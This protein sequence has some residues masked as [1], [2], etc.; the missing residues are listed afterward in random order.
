MFSQDT[1]GEGARAEWCGVPDRRIFFATDVDFSMGNFVRSMLYGD[2]EC[3]EVRL[4][5]IV[6]HH[7]VDEEQ[8]REGSPGAIS[9]P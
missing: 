8:E 9:T 2:R 6:L 7:P 4:R 5:D 3:K 1:V